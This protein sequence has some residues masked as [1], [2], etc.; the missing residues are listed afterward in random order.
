MSKVLVVANETVGADEL[1]SELRRLE[2]EKTSDY[3]VMVP[4][5]PLHERHGTV[6]TQEGAIEAA[7]DRLQQTLEVLRTEGLNAQGRVGDM[8]PLH[9]I[10]DALMDFKADLIVISTHPEKRSR[11]L[12]HGLVEQAERRFAKPVIH[13]VSTAAAVPH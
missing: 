12:R 6:W 11:W 2:D 4:A 10:N 8:R 7:E 13:V 1:L 9:A 5:R 3:Y